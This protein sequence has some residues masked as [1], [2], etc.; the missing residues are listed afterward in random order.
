MGDSKC[1]VKWLLGVFVGASLISGLSAETTRSRA[2]AESAAAAKAA[3]K[4]VQGTVFRITK[5]N[6][7]GDPYEVSFGQQVEIDIPYVRVPISRSL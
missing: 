2:I 6:P 5:E 3:V 4:G 1:N 7:N